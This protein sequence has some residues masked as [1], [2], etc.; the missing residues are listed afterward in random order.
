MTNRSFE[1]EQRMILMAEN[2]DSESWLVQGRIDLL[3]AML[4]ARERE[5]IRKKRQKI[6]VSRWRDGYP[7]WTIE[8]E[9]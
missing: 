9:E 6:S 2:Q 8:D 5:T 3:W 7:H 1:A 4:R